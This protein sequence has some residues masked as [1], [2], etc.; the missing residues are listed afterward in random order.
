MSLA[1]PRRSPTDANSGVRNRIRR[2]GGLRRP[3][4]VWGYLFILPSVIGLLC[5]TLGPI[6]ASL[7]M[8]F[9]DW[10]ALRPPRFVG[11]GNFRR[12]SEDEL[13]RTTLGN[14]IYYVGLYVPLVTV[15]A[16][17]LAN[18]LDRRL[19]GITLYRTVFFMPS[20]CM[21]VSVALLWQY[22]YQPDSGLLNYLLSL[23]GIQG[24]GW[25]TDQKWAMPALVTMG[26][27]RHVGYYALIFLAGLQSVPQ[28]LYE[29]AEVDGAGPWAKLRHMTV[30]LV[31]PTT[32]FVLVIACIEAFQLFGEAYVMTAGGPG[33]A[34]TTLVFLIYRNA[35]EGF[36]MGYAALQSWVLFAIIFGVTLVQ[37]RLNKERNYGLEG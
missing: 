30:P 21:F 25:L 17:L 12:L 18:L 27:W 23:L 22:I 5:F 10:T 7:G 13:F 1:L 31:A 29:A 19:K 16:F 26:I 36:Q 37:W 3:E 20:V 34:T 11:L 2:A 24:P 9:T 35:F 14:T 6:V 15:F 33:Y 32:F 4:I 28:E 8:I